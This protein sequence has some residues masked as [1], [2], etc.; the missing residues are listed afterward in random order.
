MLSYRHYRTTKY[1]KIYIE[2]KLCVTVFAYPQLYSAL[3]LIEAQGAS[4]KQT[5][6]RL[7]YITGPVVSGL[8]PTRKRASVL[9]TICTPSGPHWSKRISP[10]TLTPSLISGVR[11]QD[12]N[13]ARMY[14]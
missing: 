4:K 7:C 5:Y 10:G 14:G 12:R 2:F 1:S 13:L 9:L 6:F 8:M 11:P 3:K